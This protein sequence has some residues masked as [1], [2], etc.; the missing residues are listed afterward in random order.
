MNGCVT[1]CLVLTKLLGCKVRAS[2]P[3]RFSR[4]QL[5]CP[6]QRPVD[7]W[8]WGGQTSVGLELNVG[9]Q[10]LRGRVMPLTPPLG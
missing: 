4:S 10:P 3:T 2:V 9:V 8:S 6:H 7:G 5:P 1:F